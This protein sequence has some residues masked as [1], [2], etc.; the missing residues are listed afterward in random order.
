MQSKVQ[1]QGRGITS[2]KNAERYVAR[3]RAVWVSDTA[4][5]F[6]EQATVYGQPMQ[7]STALEYDRIRRPLRPA[8]LRRIPFVGNVAYLMNA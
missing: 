3:R 2:R 6:V 7:R 8:E 5:R 1:I 4:I